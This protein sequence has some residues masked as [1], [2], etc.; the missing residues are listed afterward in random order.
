MRTAEPILVGRRNPGGRTRRSRSPAGRDGCGWL[1]RPRLAALA[2]ETAE[3]VSPPEGRSVADLA[4]RSTGS[5]P[6]TPPRPKPIGAR[7]APER[8]LP[9]RPLFRDLP[10]PA[11]M[12]Q[13]RA[14]MLYPWPARSRALDFRPASRAVRSPDRA[15]A[16]SL[17]PLPRFR[18]PGPLEAGQHG[19]VRAG[20]QPQRPF[21]D[22]V[23]RVDRP[24]GVDRDRIGGSNGRGRAAPAA[25]LADQIG[26]P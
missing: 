22:Q 8:L 23:E 4:T 5:R 24:H 17:R 14:L 9:R 21:R 6:P 25:N 16:P 1:P 2:A 12:P 19:P 26:R 10:R 18:P 11:A 3:L 13:I 7:S 15:G 20:H